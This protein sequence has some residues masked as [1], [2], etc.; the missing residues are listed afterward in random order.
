MSDK[1]L[2]DLEQKEFYELIKKRPEYQVEYFST[3]LMV[4]LNKEIKKQGLDI[5][6]LSKAIGMPERQLGRLLSDDTN[7]L[8]IDTLVRIAFALNVF[9]KL[10]L[11]DKPG[12]N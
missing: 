9:I 3:S 10:E 5:L 8:T 11:R 7:Q 12:E 1:P 4:I 6:K 2:T